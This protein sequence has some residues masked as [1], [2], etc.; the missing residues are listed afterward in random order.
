MYLAVVADQTLA[1]IDGRC[2]TSVAGIL[3][4]R[5]A[6]DS[7]FLVGDSVE[8]RADHTLDKPGIGNE[9]GEKD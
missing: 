3:F 2:L 9:G 1:H 6:E 4:E 5:K 8:H 7:N